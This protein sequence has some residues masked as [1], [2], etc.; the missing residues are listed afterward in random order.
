VNDG[1]LLTPAQLRTYIAAVRQQTP[2]GRMGVIGL[3]T[4]DRWE[5]PPNLDCEGEQ[6]EVVRAESV[7]GIREALQTVTGREERT[8]LLTGLD[9]VD[10]GQDLLARM[11]GGRLVPIELWESVRGLFRAKQ[12]DPTV[13]GKSIA[14]AL[15][16]H[17]PASGYPP[18]PAGVLDAATVWRSLYR[19]V[20]QMGDGDPDLAGL[21][22]WA[23][24]MPA[25]VGRYR[26]A[27]EELRKAFRERLTSTLGDAAGS[28]LD[29]IDSNHAED[30]LALGVVCGVVYGEGEADL[31]EAAARLERFHGNTAI[32]PAIGGQLARAAREAG[33]AV[34]AADHAGGLVSH[35]ARAD[36]ILR[37]VRADHHAHRSDLTPLGLE[38]RLEQ[39]AHT[40]QDVLGEARVSGAAPG[41]ELTGACEESARRVA[42]HALAQGQPARLKSLRM[43]TRLPRW[44]FASAP[45]ARDLESSAAVF[46]D[47]QA[48]ADWAREL[49]VGG[50]DHPALSAA[51][52]SLEQVVRQRREAF[53]RSFS[54]LLAEATTK[55]TPPAGVVPVEGFL[56]KVLVP[57]AGAGH[58]LLVIVL[59][60]MSWAVAHELLD[61]LRGGHWQEL[62]WQEDGAA[63]PSLLAAIPSI[64]EVSRTS[65]LTGQLRRGNA[66]D[67]KR[68]F[69]EHSALS[70]ACARRQP[71]VLFHKAELTE[72]S[73]GG[74]SDEVAEA[75][76]NTDRRVV[77]VVI[78]AID[79]RLEGAQQVRD[80]WSVENI[81][82][83]GALLQAARDAGRVV[84]LASDHGH[85]WHREDSVL[86][87]ADGGERWRPATGR[88]QANEVLLE[89]SRVRTP[90][91]QSRVIVPLDEGLRYSMARN[92]YHGGATPQEMLA[93][94]VL[95]TPVSGQSRKGLVPCRLPTPS[96][97]EEQAPEGTPP[98]I[99]RRTRQVDAMMISLPGQPDLF[100]QVPPPSAEGAEEVVAAPPAVPWPEKLLSSPAY[101]SQ[102]ELVQ[103]HLPDDTTV[104]RCMEALDRHG[105]TL[106][107]A[108]L[109]Q[110]AGILPL[111]LD[112]LLAKLQRL[113]NVDGYEVL[114]I[115]HVQNRVTLNVPLLHRQFELD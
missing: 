52:R 82:P 101:Q 99:E 88:A 55:S 63:P 54:H 53:N 98:R 86:R 89:G 44:L 80:R 70:A 25:G 38:Q 50:D 40:I 27:R 23:A 62:S 37:E 68:L 76:L 32:P 19:H 36:Q 9:P 115:D 60:G 83:L 109:A 111:R 15:L 106:T 43:A 4:S 108:A 2:P 103:K 85:V 72:G 84:V 3:R 73:R 87:K 49:L 20:F 74:L 46:R 96:W 95:L 24:T 93:P 97:W 112:G 59:D 11:A 65:L 90:Q 81:R 79:D 45:D 17:A 41:V 42:A 28:I 114:M 67:E 18:V 69:A 78:N 94:L 39:F 7:L 14:Q 12:T 48:F 71:P 30:A 57:L 56:D 113:L 22:L 13:R 77:G 105:G 51:Y 91:D 100:T 33:G 75:I 16:D 6:Y 102:K 26:S 35:L 110:Q 1:R 21:L 58:R 8:I 92:G 107:P 47:D 34:T 104:M 66:D 29:V 5:G 61:G 31:R 10:L 64:T